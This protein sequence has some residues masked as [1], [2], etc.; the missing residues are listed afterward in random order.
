MKAHIFVDYVCPIV[1]N[2]PHVMRFPLILIKNSQEASPE[3]I[4]APWQ[5]GQPGLDV[6]QKR[7]VWMGS[8]CYMDGTFSRIIG[9]GSKRKCRFWECLLHRADAHYWDVQVEM[10]VPKGY[11][12]DNIKMELMQAVEQDE[13]N[14]T[15]FYSPECI[16]Y[17]INRCENFAEILVVGCLT[18]MWDAE[19]SSANLPA[20]HNDPSLRECVPCITSR[21]YDGPLSEENIRELARKVVFSEHEGLFEAIPSAE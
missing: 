20:L 13:M 6:L 18:G 10:T 3:L 2:T 1:Q 11:S 15:E 16:T 7:D 8:N 21:E 5:L 17:L 14:L 12:L 19:N 9:V 4:T